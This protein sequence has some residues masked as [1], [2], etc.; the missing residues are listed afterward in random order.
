MFDEFVMGLNDTLQMEKKKMREAVLARRDAMPAAARTAAS[1]AILE[2]VHTMPA[3]VNAKVV[4]TFVGF[5]SEIETQAFFERVVAD[6]KMAVLP[7][8]DRGSQSLILHSVR[9]ISELV[10]SK[11]GIREPL[12]SAPQVSIGA[13]EFVLMPGVAFDR[14]GNRLGYGRGYYDRL[15]ASADPSLARVAAAYS[16]QVVDRVPVGAGDRQVHCIITES[17]TIL[18]SHDR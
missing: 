7:R 8:V 4:L 10:T 14:A 9:G 6:G 12:P 13:V 11:W 2:K 15:V 16:C 5:G 18:I 3:Y 17:E 1:I